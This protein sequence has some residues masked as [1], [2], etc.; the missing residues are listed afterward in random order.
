M[1]HAKSSIGVFFTFFTVG[2][3]E[4]VFL[5]LWVGKNKN[6]HRK[7]SV[8]S[9]SGPLLCSVSHNIHRA[10]ISGLGSGDSLS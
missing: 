3:E 5:S 6:I 4:L 2:C 1:L 7:L 10:E 9:C 8:Q